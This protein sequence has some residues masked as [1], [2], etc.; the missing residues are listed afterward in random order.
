MQHLKIIETPL[1]WI[2]STLPGTTTTTL[3]IS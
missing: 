1:T 3:N 2:Q